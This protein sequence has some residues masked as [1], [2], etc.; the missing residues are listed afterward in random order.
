MTRFWHTALGRWLCGKWGHD[1]TTWYVRH[2][3]M[4]VR[5]KRCG[6]ML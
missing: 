2:D 6:E 1:D 4:T 5:C 3:G